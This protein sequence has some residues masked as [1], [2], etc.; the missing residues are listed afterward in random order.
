MRIFIICLSIL[1]SITEVTGQN[2]TDLLKYSQQRPGGTARVV[3]VGGSFGA[4]GGDYGGVSINPA[5]LGNY[6]LSEFTFS[7]SATFT[8]AETILLDGPATN[9]RDAKINLANA[10]IV[11]ASSP[12]SSN[13]KTSSLTFGYNRLANFNEQFTFEGK[14][15]GSIL[16]RYL[17][18][19]NGLSP[20]ELDDFE[21]GL[22]YEAGAIYE[23]DDQNNYLVDFNPYTTE[24]NKEQTID[25]KGG[26]NEFVIGWGGN[27]KRKLNIGATLGVPFINF[28]ES[29]LYQERDRDNEIET[30][31]A[32]TFSEYVKTTGIGIKMSVGATYI[33]NNSLRIGAAYHTRSYM[34]L[35]DSFNTISYYAYTFDGVEEAFDSSSPQ[36]VFDYGVR[37]PSKTV[38]SLGYLFRKN[39]V[40]GFL[41]LD[42]EYIDHSRG[43]FNLTRSNQSNQADADYE[44]EINNLVELEL[45]NSINI[46]LGSELAMGKWRVRGGAAFNQSPFEEDNGSF[47]TNISAGVGF[48]SDNFYIDLAGRAINNTENYIPYLM[49]NPADD[50]LVN[51]DI[52]KLELIMTAGFVF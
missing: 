23:P 30:F 8:N 7:P 28:E 14:T 32:L 18:Q 38:A 26:V 13:W 2:Y 47:E 41:N 19:A 5:A 43:S 1:F 52:N 37:T 36:G 42:V 6:W 24:V 29:K 11:F 16:G 49:D 31:D 33:V 21:I 50:Q 3:G 10:A 27:Y 17:E 12:M 4:M 25:R 9:E 46:R 40:A 22:A 34:A 39:K 20:N 48:R 51:V 15:V 35:K 44:E 45:S